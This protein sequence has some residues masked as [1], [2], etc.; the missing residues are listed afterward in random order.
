MQNPPRVLPDGFAVPDAGTGS[1]AA[2]LEETL[3]GLR[4]FRLLA[5]AC[6]LNL[7][8]ACSEPVTAEKLSTRL[9]LH[10]QLAGLFLRALAARQLLVEHDGTYQNSPFSARYLDPSSPYCLQD[11]VTLQLHLAGLWDDLLKILREGPRIYEPEAWFSELIIPAMAANARCGILQKT[12]KA[13][14]GLPEFR[15]ARTLLD[16][17]GGH[18]LYTIAF[19]QENPALNGVVFDLPG[20]LPATRRYIEYYRADRVS[21]IPGNFFTDP[22]GS[23][24]D[25]IFSSSNPGGKAPALIPKIRDALRPGGLFINKQGNENVLDVPLMNLEWNLWAISGVQKEPRQYSFSHSVPFEEYNRLLG[26]Q[27]FVVQD[28]IALD[29]QSIMTIARKE[30]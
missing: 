13:V 16:M 27:G 20:V 6:S 9:G 2:I 15:A 1:P 23:G 14:S 25:I 22:L 24:F 21:C 12:V 8:A 5:A 10:P 17:G 18:G 3:N 28:V 11:Q 19:C 30:Q 4:H 29:E 26:E 7:F